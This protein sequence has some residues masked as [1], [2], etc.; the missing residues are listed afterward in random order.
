MKRKSV[1]KKTKPVSEKDFGK[2]Y[3][4]T[5]SY[6]KYLKTTADWVP[7]VARK[8]TKIIKR[9][10]AEILD[11]GCA[12]GF[13]IAELRKKHSFRVRGIEYSSYARKNAVPEVKKSIEKGNILKLPFKK[14]SFDAVICLDVVNYLNDLGEVAEAVKNLVDVSRKYIFFGAIF[15][16]SW[17]AS[18]EDNPDELR[19][20]VFSKKEYVDCF[21]KAGAKLN[22]DFDGNN[23]GRILSF[24]KIKK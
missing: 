19:K 18:Q 22:G 15:K 11:V 7:F 12:Q 10:G 9:P 17:T 20:T 21:Q 14:E 5:G 24:T 4:C 13:L 8:I 6:D 23:G 2:K 16:H 1:S 3:F